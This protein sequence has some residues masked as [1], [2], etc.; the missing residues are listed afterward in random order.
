MLTMNARLLLCCAAVLICMLSQSSWCADPPAIQTIA[1]A[2]QQQGMASVQIKFTRHYPNVSS[3]LP[4]GGGAA[5][6]AGGIPVAPADSVKASEAILYVQTSDALYR[7]QPGMEDA[8]QRDG[9]TRLVS[10][11]PKT[12]TADGS[13]SG[14]SCV[15][16][17]MR[18]WGTMD[19]IETALYPLYPRADDEDTFFLQGGSNAAPLPKIKKPSM[20]MHAGGW[21]FPAVRARS[22]IAR[23]GSTHLSAL[24]H[25]ACE[26]PAATSITAIGA[27]W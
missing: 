18:Y 15:R 16:G 20:D 19:G 11:R 22:R 24:V 4:S 9:A 3:D 12:Q 14:V 17:A 21:T 6:D 10:Y 2:L 1:A 27:L 26:C 25:A 8:S 5:Q 23:S 13:G 7:K